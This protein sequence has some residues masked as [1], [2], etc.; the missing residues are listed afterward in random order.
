MDDIGRLLNE[1]MAGHLTAA[2]PLLDLFGDAGMTAERGFLIHLVREVRELIVK[3]GDSPHKR[4]VVISWLKSK[5]SHELWYL[6][7]DRDSDLRADEALLLGSPVARENMA[8]DGA[9]ATEG[10][11]RTRTPRG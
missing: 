6:V 9:E 11:R 4:S 8:G 5:V 2:V 1:L 3:Y 10:S 7:A